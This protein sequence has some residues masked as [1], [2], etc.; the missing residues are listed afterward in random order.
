LEDIKKEGE[1][2]D[3]WYFETIESQIQ[4]TVQVLTQELHKA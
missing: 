2:K 3:R 1:A 4:S